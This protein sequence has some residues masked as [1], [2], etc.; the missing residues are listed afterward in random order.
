MAKHVLIT[1][2]TGLIGSELT[3]ILLNKG[4]EVS[5]LSRSAGKTNGVKT[6]LWDVNKGIIDEQ[7]INGV[8]TVVHLAGAGIADKRWTEKRKQEIIDSRTKS[9]GLIYTALKA[10]ANH[11]VKHVVSA[12]GIGYYSDRGDELMTEDKTPLHDFLG[13][14][15]M[16][17]EKAVDKGLELGLSITKF[18]T[19]VVLTKKEGALPQL[20]L[21]VK[22]GVGSPLGS[23]KQYVSWIH[24]HDAVN[25]YVQVV[26]GSLT[27]D[28]YN[29]AAPNP[30]TNAQLTQAVAK[31]LRRPLWVPNVPAFVIKLLFGELSTLV[32][33][34]TCTSSQKIEKAG[35]HFKFVHVSDALKDIY[36]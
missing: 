28:T 35:Y 9:I 26:E 31:Q 8:D 3:Q 12:S 20:A 5:H 1:G 30:V 24:L 22:F 29:M 27:P 18:R 23:G 25:M 21:P 33:G 34:S 32:L 16:E 4:Y 13:T 17:W 6:F 19:G 14:C 15:C 10:N 2:G 36:G 7:C 11:T